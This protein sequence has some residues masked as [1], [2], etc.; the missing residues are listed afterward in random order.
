M[1]W[2]IVLWLQTHANEVLQQFGNA[3]VCCTQHLNL[4][5][6]SL[7]TFPVLLNPIPTEFL[8]PWP[9]SHFISSEAFLGPQLPFLFFYLSFLN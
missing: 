7:K 1:K 4:V 9:F 2:I 5:H 6:N 3:D 8:D